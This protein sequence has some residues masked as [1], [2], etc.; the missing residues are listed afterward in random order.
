MEPFAGMPPSL[1]ILM[2][3]D[4]PLEAMALEEDLVKLG[5][6][7]CGHAYSAGGGILMAEKLKPDLVMSDINLGGSIDGIA[8]AMEIRKHREVGVIFITGHG[9]E[10][11]RR[12]AAEVG[13]VG[14]LLKPYT[15]ET[16][17]EAVG[18]AMRA[19]KPPT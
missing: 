3:E 8:M 4:Q 16:L 19:I 13:P 1:R 11:T 9:D 2:V 18:A 14:F 17:A 10:E 12:R 7:V 5:Q 15:P 6:E